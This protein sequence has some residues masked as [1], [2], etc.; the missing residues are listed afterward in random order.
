VNIRLTSLAGQTKTTTIEKMSARQPVKNYQ[1][2]GVGQYFAQRC[3]T[4]SPLAKTAVKA[5]KVECVVKR[6]LFPSTK[7][8]KC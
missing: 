3:A 1:L 5:N 2:V 4:A 8:N 6:I 7:L